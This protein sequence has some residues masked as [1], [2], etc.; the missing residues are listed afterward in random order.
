MIPETFE[1]IGKLTRRAHELE[2]EVLVDIH[3]QYLEQIQI[4]KQVDWVYDFA[5]SPLVLHALYSGD[6]ASPEA[7]A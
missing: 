4:A 5:L 6:T 1:F 7:M 2:I 3:S